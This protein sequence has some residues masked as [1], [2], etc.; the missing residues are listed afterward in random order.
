MKRA[1]IATENHR[2]RGRRWDELQSLWLENG[3]NK[4]ERKREKLFPFSARDLWVTL[5]TLYGVTKDDRFFLPLVA[6]YDHHI[7]DFD[8]GQFRKNWKSPQ[9]FKATAGLEH[10]LFEGIS[11]LVQAGWSLH[12]TC[13]EFAAQCPIQANSF[14]AAVKKLENLYASRIAATSQ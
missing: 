3:G 11:D 6:L 10:V 14:E 7:V 4:R 2:S 9:E 13:A 5:K 8:K 12:R 1:E